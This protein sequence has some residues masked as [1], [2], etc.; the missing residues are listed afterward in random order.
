MSKKMTKADW[1]KHCKSQGISFQN[2]D[3]VEMLVKALA[4]SI[5]IKSGNKKVDTLKEEVVSGLEYLKESAKKKT[6]SKKSSSHIGDIE[7]KLN[8]ANMLITAEKK[9][10]FQKHAQTVAQLLD[11]AG[12]SV[13]MAIDYV[14]NTK[15]F[16]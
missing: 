15:N 2:N 5:G 10:L 4:G 8:E 6:A 7:S 1:Q 11:R 16:K 12:A 3:T 14:R 9:Q 13:L